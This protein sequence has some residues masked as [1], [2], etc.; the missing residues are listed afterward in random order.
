MTVYVS[1]LKGHY[2][3]LEKKIKLRIVMFTIIM[4]Y[5]ILQ[6]WLLHSYRILCLR[7]RKHV[8]CGRNLK[9]PAQHRLNEQTARYAGFDPVLWSTTEKVKDYVPRRPVSCEDGCL[10]VPLITDEAAAKL[11]L[12]DLCEEDQLKPSL[13]EG[14]TEFSKSVPM[15]KYPNVKQA[16][17]KILCVC[18]MW[19]S[20]VTQ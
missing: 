16:A 4:W 9:L 20:A 11:E 1:K 2:V 12:I 13:R 7:V 5:T 14:T 15:E 6:A 8:W 10:K 19:L 3:V 18:M 17:L